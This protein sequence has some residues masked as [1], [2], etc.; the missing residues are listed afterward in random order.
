MVKQALR[1][2]QINGE[3]PRQ[4]L[5]ITLDIL[6]DLHSTCDILQDGNMLWAAMTMAFYG[7]LRASEFTTSVSFD[8]NIHLCNIDVTFGTL[9]NTPFMK[10]FIKR[11]KTDQ[12]NRGFTIN[13]S[14]VPDITCAVCAMHKYQSSKPLQI[15]T[16]PLF[17]FASGVPLKKTLFQ[18]N[19]NLML[20]FKNYPINEFSGHSLRIGSATT[21]ASVGLQDWEIKLLGRWTSDAYHRYIT[22]STPLLLQISKRLTNP[23]PFSQLYNYRNPYITNII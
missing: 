11:S 2:L 19:L 9:E 15:P 21:G 12:S 8:S 4:K 14:C 16:A 3:K 22:A 10:V 5:P 20:S 23:A 13:I 17:V 6:R 1:A 18:K 7:C